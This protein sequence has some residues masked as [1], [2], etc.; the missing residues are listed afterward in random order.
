[1]CR[2]ILRGLAYLLNTKILKTR[3]KILH[4][5]LPIVFQRVNTSLLD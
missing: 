5:Y 3:V 1:M 4:I 2:A